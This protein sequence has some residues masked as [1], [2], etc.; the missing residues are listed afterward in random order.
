MESNT[1]ALTAVRAPGPSEKNTGWEEQVGRRVMWWEGVAPRCARC[2]FAAC[3]A[4]CPAPLTV[5]PAH[6]RCPRPQSPQLTR[7]HGLE[8]EQREPGEAGDRVGALQ[9]GLALHDQGQQAAAGA[10]G[11]EDKC[12]AQELGVQVLGLGDELLRGLAGSAVGRAAV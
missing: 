3:L 6:A 7:Q 1:Q 11:E 9:D 5:A 10:E 8:G 4:A 12:A 2:N